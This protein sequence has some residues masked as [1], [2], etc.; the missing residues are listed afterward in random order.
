MRQG[1]CVNY[2]IHCSQFIAVSLSNV[3]VECLAVVNIF[4]PR[5]GRSHEAYSSLFVCVCVCARVCV[6]VRN[7]YL[8]NRLLLS[9]E[10]SNTGRS[11]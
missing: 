1:I 7:A 4:M 3:H 2:C 8:S 10:I 5:C 6:Y 11:Q 9:A